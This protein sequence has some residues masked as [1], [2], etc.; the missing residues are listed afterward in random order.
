M[1]NVE[2][3][4]TRGEVCCLVLATSVSLCASACSGDGARIVDTT[5]GASTAVVTAILVRGTEADHTYLVAGAEL[6][7]RVDISNAPELSGGSVWQTDDAIYVGENERLQRYV[8]KGDYSF[9]LTGE[10]SLIN[11]GID[12]WWSPAAATLRPR[13]P[14]ARVSGR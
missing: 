10:F 1:W 12:Y 9:E 14:R 8:V 3:P 11:Y 5:E 2:S 4:K 6:P 13:P 7:S